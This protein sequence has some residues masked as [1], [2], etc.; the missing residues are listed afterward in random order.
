MTENN[1][2]W[3]SIFA[4]DGR[5]FIQPYDEMPAF[6]ARLKEDNAIQ[7]LD[8][9]C[10]T[11]RHVV[12]LAR[13]GFAVCGMDNA[14]QGLAM[15]RHWLQ[16]EGLDAELRLGDMLDRYPFEDSTFDAVLS[17]SVIHHARLAQ[18][19]AVIAE[20]WRVLKPGGLAFIAVPWRDRVES[21]ES[22]AE[23]I[24]PDTFVPLE[25]SE[26]GLPHHMFTEDTL[27][28]AFGAFEI[29]ETHIDSRERNVC[30]TARKP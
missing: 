25:G 1:T 27:R 18:V 23:E 20:I 10:G 9:G 29:L 28:Q 11:G 5:I 3:N 26:K 22:D 7:V 8:L 30:L 16:A 21:G 19:Q 6:I 12:Y 13:E 4:K 15:T 24:E 17:I 14:P 2:V